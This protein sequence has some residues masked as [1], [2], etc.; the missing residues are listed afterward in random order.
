MAGGADEPNGGMYFVNWLTAVLNVGIV[1]GFE[2]LVLIS[3]F[4]NRF[5]AN[6][7]LLQRAAAPEPSSWPLVVAMILAPV[8]AAALFGLPAFALVKRG[9]PLT[10]L[11]LSAL[12]YLLIL[13]ILRPW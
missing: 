11:G 10:A 13:D 9:S 12:P 8:V 5:A 4:G 3:W 1:L 6:D 2:L 7:G